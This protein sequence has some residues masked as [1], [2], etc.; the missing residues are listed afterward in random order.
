MDILSSSQKTLITARGDFYII[1]AAMT[2]NAVTSKEFC[3][4]CVALT[5]KKLVKFS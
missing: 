4:F 2:K 1:Y 5:N 3:C